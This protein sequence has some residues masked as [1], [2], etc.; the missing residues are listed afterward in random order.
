MN[1]SGLLVLATA[2]LLA[3]STLANDWD[4]YPV[5]TDPGPGME[6]QLLPISDDFNYET[7]SAEFHRRWKHGLLQQTG[8][9]IAADD[10]VS[11]HR[12][13]LK[14]LSSP[15]PVATKIYAGGIYSKEQFEYPVFFEIMVKNNRLPNV[16]SVKL[17]N[18]RKHKE[19]KIYEAIGSDRRGESWN[20]TRLHLAHGLNSPG[21]FFQ[22]EGPNTWHLHPDG[23]KWSDSYNRVGIF[24]R[25][26]WTI[27]YYVNGELIETASGES[28][29]DP[30]GLTDGTGLNGIMTL[31]IVTENKDYRVNEGNI[32]TEAELLDPEKNAMRIDWIRAYKPVDSNSLGSQ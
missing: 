11:T 17:L 7:D 13:K 28:M 20:A 12:G 32:P 30:R 29:I 14:L 10:N 21:G 16:S 25:D 19:V 1:C 15:G 3:K 9:T 2:L 4:S 22:P 5:P 6:W 18:E 8:G 24:W 27:E 23:G 26:P 31:V